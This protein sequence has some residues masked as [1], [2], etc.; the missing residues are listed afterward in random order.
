MTNSRYL[1]KPRTYKWN[2]CSV[3]SMRQVYNQKQSTINWDVFIKD[4]DYCNSDNNH[5]P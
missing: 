5:G 1:Y 3:T 2:V 4:E